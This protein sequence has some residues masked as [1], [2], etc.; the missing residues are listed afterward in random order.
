MKKIL[1]LFAV[2][3]MAVS[4]W[5]EPITFTFVT[6][7]TSS[8]GSSSKTAIADIFATNGNLINSVTANKC[9]QGANGW[10]LKMGNSSTN[11]SLSFTLKDAV[12]LDSIV[13]TAS[14]Y[15]ATENTLKINGTSFT[16]GDAKGTF[17]KA[18]LECDGETEISTI[19]LQ[20]TK[21]V[22]VNELT[23][24]VHE[25]DDPSDTRTK[26]NLSSFSATTTELVLGGTETTTTTVANDQNTWTPA[27]TYTSSNTEVATVDANGIV[28][29]VA[30]GVAEITVSLNIADDDA[31]WKVGTTDSKTITITVTDPSFQ[32]LN[33]TFNFVTNNYGLT[34]GADMAGAYIAENTVISSGLVSIKFAASS[35]ARYGTYKSNAELRIYKSKDIKF[36][37]PAGCYLTKITLNS[38]ENKYNYPAQ[39]GTEPII[40]TGKQQELTIQ[41]VGATQVIQ[42]IT[43]EYQTPAAGTFDPLT[44][45]AAGYATF[46]NATNAVELPTGVTGSVFCAGVLQEIYSVENDY[47]VIPAG[48]PV[49]LHAAAGTYTLNYTTTANASYKS[50]GA[51]DLCGAAANMTA[52]E[53][54]AANPGATKF[55]SLSLNAAGEVNS[56][57]FYWV[58]ANGAAFNIPAGKAYLAL[59]ESA[60]PAHFLFEN[61]E[62]TATSIEAIEAEQAVKFIENGQLIIIKNGVR[63]NALGQIVK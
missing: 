4:M 31:N 21:R 54:V 2:M 40:W 14:P 37:V 59:A 55:Y 22:Y 48:E 42:S 19:T 44:I 63:Y 41:F 17:T 50:Y 38:R 53:M 13:A 25:D 43:I 30:D 5:A 20:G 51:N 29:A 3:F 61:E 15:S 45:G 52:S 33:T 56:V 27:Y 23:L 32:K 57:G 62:Q 11:G 35:A 9:M 49:V 8:D 34:Q 12:I 28:T 18:K 1:S 47:A 16:L 26:V 58:A 60:A 24:Y 39:E 6:S 46:F 36:S 7:G 10:G